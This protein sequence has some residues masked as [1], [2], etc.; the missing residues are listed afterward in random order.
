MK[1]FKKQTLIRIIALLGVA[2]IVF[3]ALL[4]AFT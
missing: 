4:P 2:A 1:K 3:T